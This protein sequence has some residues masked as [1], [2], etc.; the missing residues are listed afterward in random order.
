VVYDPSAM[1]TIGDAIGAAD[2]WPG[3]PPDHFKRK[4]EAAL[5]ARFAPGG[6]VQVFARHSGA[7]P[8]RILFIEDTVPLRRTGS[9]FVRA[10]DLVHAMAALG[11]SVTVFPVNGSDHDPALVFGDMADSVEVM[12]TLAVDRLAAFLTD[13]AGYYDTV[14]VA[15]THNLG[16]VRPILDRSVADGTLRARIVLDTEAVTPQREAMQAAL[17][18]TP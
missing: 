13:R 17:T 1:I 5:A 12:H 6:P 3:S 9:G 18:G 14:W 15:R 8:H 4:H 10:N 2:G 11:F 16:R 7:K